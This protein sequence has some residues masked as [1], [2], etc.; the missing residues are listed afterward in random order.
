MSDTLNP[1]VIGM[2]LSSAEGRRGEILVAAFNVFSTKGYEGGT[3]RDIATQVGVT[4]PALYRHFKSKEDIFL[5]LIDTFGLRVHQYVIGPLLD[6]IGADDVRNQIAAVI[7]DRR[8]LLSQFGP[9]F[10]TI[11]AS[12]VHN[13]V[14]L[15]RYRAAII[16]PLREKISET[17]TR[18]D[19][20][21]GLVDGDQDRASRVRTV[22]SLALGTF[23]SSILIGDEVEVAA[24]DGIMRVLRWDAL[25]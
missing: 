6:G 10:T 23:V 8:Q 17:I 1:M 15:E 3:M 12:V 16:F 14:L 13:P 20:E 22:M 4:E 24:A 11:I 25:G 9:P 2:L 7:A 5:E 21:F 19:A 18:L